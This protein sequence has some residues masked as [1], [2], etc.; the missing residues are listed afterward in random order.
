MNKKLLLSAAALGI[1]LV[2]AAGLSAQTGLNGTDARPFYVMGHNPNTIADALTAVEHARCCRTGRA[3]AG[4]VSDQLLGLRRDR[5]EVRVERSSEVRRR[6]R[7]APGEP[8]GDALGEVP[9]DGLGGRGRLGLG[10]LLTGRP[11]YLGRITLM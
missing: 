3:Q 6:D 1:A 11:R 10:H 5:R 9:V 2:G 8:A 4:E 7:L